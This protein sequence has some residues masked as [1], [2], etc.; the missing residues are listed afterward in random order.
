MPR[1]TDEHAEQGGAREQREPDRC[2]R[3]DPVGAV[4]PG[5]HPDD[6]QPEDGGLDD[7]EGD[8]ERE[9]LRVVPEARLRRQGND[10]PAQRARPPAR[11]SATSASSEQV[12]PGAIGAAMGLPLPGVAGGNAC[13][14]PRS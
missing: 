14:A 11:A 5:E 4:S 2:H 13:N 12:L 9:Q 6:P 10:L 8:R 3:A 7:R 1:Q